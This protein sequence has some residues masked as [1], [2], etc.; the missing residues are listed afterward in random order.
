M[1]TPLQVVANECDKWWRGTAKLSK[2]L[3]GE[4]LEVV[5]QVWNLVWE[6]N[7]VL[8]IHSINPSFVS[9]LC[10]LLTP[11]SLSLSQVRVK[12]EDFQQHIPLIT[13]MRNP[14]LRDRHWERIT[15]AVGFP[16]KADAG[17]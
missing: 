14:G 8:A 12:L 10:Y 16:V 6:I 15:N 1:G 5:N 7:D 13:A 4:P 17:E 3:T 11:S 2:T 9:N